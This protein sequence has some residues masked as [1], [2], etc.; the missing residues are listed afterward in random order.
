MMKT[1]TKRSEP[2]Q[3]LRA[4]IINPGNECI[5]WPYGKTRGGYGSVWFNGR[6]CRAHRVSLILYSGESP[7]P[8]LEVAHAVECHN[9]ACINPRHLRFATTSENHADKV[10]NG[11]LRKGAAVNFAKLTEADVINIRVDPRV[12]AT[13]AKDFGISQPQVSRIKRGLTWAHVGSDVVNGGRRRGCARPGAKLSESDV[14]AIR[15]DERSMRQIA[16]HYGVCG[17]TISDIRRRKKWA[18]VQ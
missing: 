9:P 6:K 7:A 17:Q 5:V 14:V 10:L 2:L 12:H 3:F 18:H 16:G 13:I 4:A 1:K 11:T 15:K 8:G